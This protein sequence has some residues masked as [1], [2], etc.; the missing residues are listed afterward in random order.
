MKMEQDIRA[1]I[2]EDMADYIST[3]EFL[4]NEV[5][6]GVKVV[7]KA[8]RLSEA[9]ILIRDLL[10]DLVLL[11]IQFENEGK[12]G[13]DLLEKLKT[14]HRVSFQLI[15]ITAHFEKQHYSKAFEHNALHF[16]EKPI[17]KIRL[18]EAID[19]V[20]SNQIH[21]KINLITRYVENEIRPNYHREKISKINIRGVSFNE[22]ID[23]QEIIWIE[24]DGRKSVIYL[25]N[26][27]KVV[28]LDNIGILESQIDTNQH[29]M[30]IN[31]SEIINLCF[32]ERYSKKEK[33][34]ILT[35]SFPKHYISKDIFPGF[36]ERINHLKDN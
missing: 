24:A 36:I 6:P 26:D 18:A 15:I 27:R 12:T 32:V 19:R 29:F 28:S 5:A 20:R 35:G 25:R 17:N 1:I 34:V 3:I 13:F 11:D 30:R 7:G 23:L 9:E 22:I 31:R 14:S 33:L 16:L 2:V 10:P 21:H 8:T 4:L